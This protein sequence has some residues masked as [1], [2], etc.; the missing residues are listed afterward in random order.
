[1]YKVVSKIKAKV[2]LS[3]VGLNLDFLL[4]NA[5]PILIQ[6]TDSVHWRENRK[7]FYF[8]AERI[9][10][11]V[12][13]CGRIDCAYFLSME[14]LSWPWFRENGFGV[15]TRKSK[16]CLFSPVHQLHSLNQDQDNFFMLRKCAQSIPHIKLP[17]A[18]MLSERK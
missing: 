10:L 6:G 14:K 11:G 15:L 13:S 16:N 12:I 8:R 2:E 17:P 9:H 5:S 18:W 4:G 3:K 7:N 1:M